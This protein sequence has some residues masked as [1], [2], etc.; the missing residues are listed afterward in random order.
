[1]RGPVIPA[2]RASTLASLCRRV[3]WALQGSLHRAHRTPFTLLAV[4]EAPMPVVQ[5]TMPRSHF[6]SA[7]ARAAGS[8]KSA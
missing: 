2:P 1:M 3:I 4:M 5:M 6:P 7:A 8:Q